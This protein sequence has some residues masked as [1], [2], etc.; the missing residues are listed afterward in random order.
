MLPGTDHA[1][2][3]AEGVFSLASALINDWHIHLH[4]LH[5]AAGA[6]FIVK[7]FHFETR[8]HYLSA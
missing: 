5:W 8:P 1:L 6:A 4:Q 2:G 3:N 7:L